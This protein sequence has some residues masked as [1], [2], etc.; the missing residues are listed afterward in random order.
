MREGHRQSQH[1]QSPG[2]G[3]AGRRPQQAE[4]AHQFG[5]PADQRRAARPGDVGRHDAHF[6]FGENEVC[7]AAYEEPQKGE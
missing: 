3:A 6:C 5:P 4:G 1:R 7:D 2:G